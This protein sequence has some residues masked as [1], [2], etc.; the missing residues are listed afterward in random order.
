MESKIKALIEKHYKTAKVF[1]VTV[2]PSALFKDDTCVY[3]Q[4]SAGNNYPRIAQRILN[5]Y[6]DVRMVHFTGGWVEAVYT[7]ETLRWAG[8]R[9]I[10]HKK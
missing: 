1:S 3:I 7:R 2:E 10:D 6:P 8:Y 4:C 5:A 9:I